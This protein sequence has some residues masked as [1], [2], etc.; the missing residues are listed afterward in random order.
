MMPY[1][2]LS[3]NAHALFGSYALLL[4]T[5]AIYL[6][7]NTFALHFSL[8]SR[9]FSVCLALGCVFVLMG[10]G[11]TLIDAPAMSKTAGCIVRLSAVE[12][13]L[14]LLML[15]VL[16]VIFYIFLRNCKKDMITKESIKESLDALP[17]GVC[18]YSENGTPLLVNVQMSSI[19]EELFNS[20]IMNVNSF[21]QRLRDGNFCSDAVRVNT[22]RPVITVKTA[23]G[24]VWD[25]RKSSLLVQ[26]TVVNEL[27]A[28]NVTKQYRLNLRLKER[29]RSMNEIGKRLRRYNKEV[30]DTAREK[31]ILNA[32]VRVHDDLGRALLMLRKYL[33]QPC[34]Q[35]NREELLMLWRFNTEVMK[36]EASAVGPGTNW[37]SFIRSAENIGVRVVHRGTAPKE[38]SVKFVLIAALSECLTNVVKHAGGNRIDIETAQT[39]S[40]VLAKITNNGLPP[41]EKIKE[42]GGLKSLRTIVEGSGGKMTIE[43][44]PSFVMKIML[45]RGEAENYGEN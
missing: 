4:T 7:V 28:Y 44:S 23:D 13:A 19:C 15:T 42:A 24:Q 12:L 2:E 27:V 29:N 30:A 8:Q 17:D 41:K 10:M 5:A 3:V 38:E 11:D 26:K 22:R 31:E 34:E 1:G 36:N 40:F 32:T 16:A 43:S 35:R 18:F 14:V 37:N 20:G 25:F 39:S 21:V 33:V 45:P 9:A 6:L